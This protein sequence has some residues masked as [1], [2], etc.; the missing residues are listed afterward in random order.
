MPTLE[1]SKRDLEML[2]RKQIPE[3][4]LTETLMIAK[5]EYEGKTEEGY[6]KVDMKDV[7]RPDLWSTEGIARELRAHYGTQQGIPKPKTEKS[8]LK[9]DQQKPHLIHFSPEIFAGQGMPQL[10]HYS[11][12]EDG[13]PELNYGCQ[14]E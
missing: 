9:I 2:A 1:I 13:K 12:Q 11:N 5:G 7:N 3:K 10:M 4:D 14:V 8:G 6:L